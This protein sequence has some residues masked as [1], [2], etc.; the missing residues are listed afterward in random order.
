MRKNEKMNY[1]PRVIFNW[2]NEFVKGQDS[3]LQKI[4][5]ALS[6]HINASY[7]EAE[8]VTRSNILIVG[9]TG[10]GKT[11]TIRGLMEMDLPCP[12]PIVK[13]N[14]LDYSVGAWAGKPISE[15]FTLA[16]KQAKKI[17]EEDLGDKTDEEEIRFFALEAT[18]HSII[19]IDEF[20]K[21]SKNGRGGSDNSDSFAS[22]YQHTLLG[23]LEGG[24][25]VPVQITPATQ[26]SQGMITR[27][28]TSD[29]LFILMGA[30]DGLEEITRKRVA[31]PSQ[32]G[33]KAH[34]GNANK[35]DL[36]PS[37]DDIVNYGF[38]RELTGRIP[39][40]AKYNQLSADQLIN[41]MKNAANSPITKM[42]KRVEVL[43]F[44]LVVSEMAYEIIA[45]KAIK[46]GTGARGIEN[47]I[48][49][50]VYPCLYASAD[51]SPKQILI[52][53]NAA[54]GYEPPSVAKVPDSDLVLNEIF[55]KR[56]K[57]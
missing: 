53:A 25:E 39:I 35:L 20:D 2:L 48:A 56:K 24:T 47:I 8:D 16:F 31:P 15:I 6:I 36:T 49:D 26:S 12:L 5:T 27:I 57:K 54:N 45:E 37:V 14:A 29:M 22:D 52:G 28:N 21:V 10:C 33:F 50:I 42:E 9:P 55:E 7:A 44:N 4:S 18:K 1:T 11:E 30:F 32:I 41:I 34:E 17:I 38:S 40:R 19:I 23:I 3:A 13:V 51:G 46:L 43:N